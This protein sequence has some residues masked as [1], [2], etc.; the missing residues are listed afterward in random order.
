[1]NVLLVSQCSKRALDETRRILDQFAERKGERTWATTITQNGLDTLRKLLRKTARRNTAVSCHWL[2]SAGPELCWIVGNVHRFNEQGSVPTNSTGRN[3]LRSQDENLWH[4]GEA[5]ALLAAIAGLF[6]DLGKANRL[7]QDKLTGKRRELSEPLRHEW[8]SLRIFEAFVDSRGDLQWLTALSNLNTNDEKQALAGLGKL[9]E[10]KAHPTRVNPFEALPPI[11]RI[12]G[13]LIVSHHRLPQFDAKHEQAVGAPPLERLTVDSGRFDASWN[14]PQCRDPE[15]D[16]DAWQRVWVFPHGTPL[17]SQTWC[18]KANSLAQRALQCHSLWQERDWLS[19][20]FTAHLARL[21]LMLADHAY[22][23]GDV[24]EKWQDRDYRAYANTDRVTGRLK[25]SLDEHNIGV[26]HNAY[27][28]AKSLPK[29]RPYLPAITRHKGFKQRS[30]QSAFRWQDKAFDLARMLVHRSRQQGFF[31]VNMASTGCGKTFANARIMYGLADEKLGCRFSVALGLRT[32]T[33]QTGDALR[34]RLSLDSDDLAVLIGSAAVQQLHELRTRKA[35][36]EPKSGSESAESLL[37]TNMHVRYDG[38]LDDGPLRRWLK[39]SPALHQLVSAPVLVST[40]DHLI[41]ATE[42]TRGGKQ[43]APMLRLL[44][45]DLVLDEPDD[46]GLSDLPALCRLVN[47]AGMLGS[48]V[49]LSSATLQPALLNA[50]FAAYQAG[51]AHY[52]KACGQPGPMPPI[53]CA[54]FDEFGVAQQDLAEQSAFKVNHQEF[55]A[56]R[57]TKLAEQSALR[58]GA[59]WSVSASGKSSDEVVQAMA[60]AVRE[61]MLQ[62]HSEH[63]ERHVSGKC[64]SVGLVRMANID[65]LVAIARQVLSQA[66]PPDTHIHFC[67]Y[68]SHHPLLVRSEMEKRLDAL[69]TR[70]DSDAFWQRPEVSQALAQPEK[71]HLFVVFASPVAEVGRD[72]DYDWAIAEPSSMRSLI[73]LAGRIQ[74]HRKRGPAA[75]NLLILNRNVKALRGR[76]P[77]YCQPGFEST[78]FQLANHDM[79]Q[80]LREEQYKVI[81]AAPAIQM[82]PSPGRGPYSNLVEL[83]HAHLA[84]SLFAKGHQPPSAVSWWQHQHPLDWAGEMQRQTRFRASRPDESFVLYQADEDE[85]LRFHRLEERGEPELV[86][87]SC[88]ERQT[89]TPAERVAPWLD[90]EP[91]PLLAAL[92]EEMEWDAARLSRTF[93]EIRLPLNEQSARPWRYD[94]QFGVYRELKISKE[95]RYE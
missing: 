29:L 5:M 55:V 71:H 61:G 4:S 72:H 78:E 85:P 11:A 39:Q 76:T 59:I 1:M 63:H 94:P 24:T 91:E 22:S 25:Q 64:C 48:R 92:G 52:H 74:R 23:S 82:P 67:I 38:A 60:S 80:S 45:S 77:A 49:L 58:R 3:I 93:T 87:A 89:F 43:I 36:S 86:E 12:I 53:C 84:T 65:P 28:L 44:T 56:A 21:C 26:G 40:I 15:W 35:L 27:L 33:L 9:T 69:L 14:S 30:Q 32:L 95:G 68:H 66:P 57:L 31:G 62:L 70:Y 18:S 10:S 20:R 7:F 83:E 90:N 19:D 6:H 47:W 51:R 2:K 50:L 41:P 81:G 13:W 73:Q 37:D 79:A 54:W 16:K 8:V 46:F 34:A 75:P 42:G 17:A 88:F